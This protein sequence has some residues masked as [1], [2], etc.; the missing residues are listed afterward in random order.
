MG[1]MWYTDAF[2]FREKGSQRYFSVDILFFG[3]VAY[4]MSM[5]NKYS[6]FGNYF[7]FSM[8]IITLL[9]TGMY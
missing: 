1:F 2:L 6:F 4:F 8:Y 5:I 9:L 3:F 7:D